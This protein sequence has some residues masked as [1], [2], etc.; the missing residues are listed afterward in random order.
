MPGATG[1]AHGRERLPRLL[2]ITPDFPPSHG[3][4]QVLLSR[5]ATG[6]K[7]FEVEVVTPAFRG[8]ERFD[9]DSGIVTTRVGA[10]IV[11]QTARMLALNLRALVRARRFRPDL[12]LSGH[13]VT[14]AAAVMIRTLSGAPFAQYV[15]ATE[16]LDKPRLAAF[17]TARANAVLAVSAYSAS[18]VDTYARSHAN[19]KVIHPG[20]DL[21]TA[22]HP[23]R[24]TRPT[25]VTVA[26]LTFSYKG[27]DVLIQALAR[28]RA[29]VPDVEWVVVGDGPLRPQLEA[30]ARESGVADCTRFLGGVSDSERDEWLA[31]C[32]VMAMP[33]RPPGEGFGIAYLEAGAHGKPVIAGAVGGPREAVLD[34]VTGLSV[35]ATDPVAVAD[36][37]VRL[38]LDPELAQRLGRAGSERARSYAWPCAARRVEASL[39]EL[40]RRS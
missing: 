29:R 5:L 19:V 23:A 11:G 1:G 9:R 28:V 27:H 18:L 22:S 10:R 21:P 17:A 3:G 16:I 12:T 30:L 34:G 24:A 37:I 20:V 33:S 14:S 6:L 31:R 2:I 39:V 15:Y 4:V 35:D 36:A 40:L 13:I 26:Q 38:L 32:H 8:Y 7:G 25:V